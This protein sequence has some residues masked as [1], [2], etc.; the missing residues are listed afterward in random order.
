MN[1]TREFQSEVARKLNCLFDQYINS[2]KQCQEWNNIP[3]EL[4]QIE[5]DN[6]RY[7]TCDQFIHGY[8]LNNND[9]SN[10][11]CAELL[12]KSEVNKIR[13]RI[14]CTL[15]TNKRSLRLVRL[16]E[17]CSEPQTCYY[18]NDGVWVPIDHQIGS[19]IYS[20]ILDIAIAPSIYMGAKRQN[21]FISTYPLLN[22]PIIF[23]ALSKISYIQRLKQEFVTCTIENY[24]R[25]GIEYHYS[26]TNSRPLCLFGIEIE[27]SNDKKHLMGDFIN[28][29]MLSKYPVVIVPDSKLI[30]CLELIK[31]TEVVYKLKEI[32]VFDHINKVMLLSISQF[33]AVL[34]RILRENGI[35]QLEVEELS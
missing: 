18:D 9:S 5:N 28:S 26:E 7:D 35:A 10:L 19:P 1:L 25:I 17:C 12:A 33:R 24:R 30:S 23:E 20:P 8:N 27:N 16:L 4:R 31:L 14:R 15:Y 21:P 11:L 34:N 32:G 13:E 2:I 3:I 29:F 6:Y 22:G